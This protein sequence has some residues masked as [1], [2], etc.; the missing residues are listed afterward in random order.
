[1]GLTFGQLGAAHTPVTTNHR[2]WTKPACGCILRTGSD[3]VL[4]L[5][6]APGPAPVLNT[7]TPQLDVWRQRMISLTSI[8]GLCGCPQVIDSFSLASLCPHSILLAFLMATRCL[9]VHSSS[10]ISYLHA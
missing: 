7:P 9:L 3:G 6:T 1:V 10:P 2:Y 8:A 4:M 5:P